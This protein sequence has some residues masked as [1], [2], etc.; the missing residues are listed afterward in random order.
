MA[1]DDDRPKKSWR[2]I[3][4]AKDKSSHRKE[5]GGGHRPERALRSQAY[6]A[7]KTQLN[8][9]F[10]GGS[11]PDALKNKLEEAGVG[12]SKKRKKAC[13]SAILEAKNLKAVQ[14]ALEDH[15]QEFGFPDDEEVLA[16]LLEQDSSK[17]VLDTLAMIETLLAESRLKRGSSLKARI[18]TAQ[19]MLDSPKVNEAALALLAKM[20]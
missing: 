8:K 11:L 3:D 12:S 9:L 18:K 2:E 19:M 20:L 16:K 5:E 6:R 10:D 13:V 4:S 7:Y 1:N 14:E 15:R 17:I